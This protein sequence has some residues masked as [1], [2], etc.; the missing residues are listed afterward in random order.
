VYFFSVFHQS[1]SGL[2]Y[3]KCLAFWVTY[4]QWVCKHQP[5]AEAFFKENMHVFNEEVGENS[6]SFIP[7]PAHN[8]MGTCSFLTKHFLLSSGKITLAR[9]LSPEYV[10][11]QARKSS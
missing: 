1:G 11:Q 4:L 7:K 5:A 10:G 2:K 3:P 8:R 6:I 9:V